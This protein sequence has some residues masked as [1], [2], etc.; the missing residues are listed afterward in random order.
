MRL[1]PGTGSGRAAPLRCRPSGTGGAA[2][3]KNLDLSGLA[4]DEVA[5]EI[6]KEAGAR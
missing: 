3:R 5:L 1:R 2:A 4:C 6:V